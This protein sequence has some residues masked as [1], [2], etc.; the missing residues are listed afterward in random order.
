MT[1]KGLQYPRVLAFSAQWASC[2]N[3]W[4][5]AGECRQLAN[6]TDANDAFAA[7]S[8]RSKQSD[9]D[10]IIVVV[11]RWGQCMK[12]VG[13]NNLLRLFFTVNSETFL[14]QIFFFQKFRV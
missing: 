6:Q 4:T 5:L 1:D 8:F 14:L 9:T 11:E 3:S 10:N 12:M 2:S 7:F 13:L